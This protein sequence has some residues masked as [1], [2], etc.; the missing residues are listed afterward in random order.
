MEISEILQ[1]ISDEYERAKR[2]YRR[3]FSSHHEA[4]A[5]ILEELDELWDEI[6]KREEHYDLI[7]QRKE[8]IQ[9]GAM[10]LRFINELT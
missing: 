5:V 10:I 6:K 2:K 7:K 3:P 8:A 4:Y 9:V 1:E